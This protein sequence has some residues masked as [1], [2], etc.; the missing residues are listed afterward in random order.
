MIGFLRGTVLEKSPNEV[1]IETSGVGY[2]V[3]IPI[4][5]FTALPSEGAPVALRIYTH[6]REDTISLFGFVTAQ[7]KTV[8]ERLISVSGIGPKLAISSRRY[9]TATCSS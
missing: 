7:E 6:V 5:T 3:T 4:S 9:G 1:I 8:F 2:E